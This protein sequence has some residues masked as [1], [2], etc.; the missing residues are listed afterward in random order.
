M[1][2]R[3]EPLTRRE[4]KELQ[5][6]VSWTTS[7]LRV[8]LFLAVVAVVAALSM[9]LQRG[10]RLPDWLWPIP[11]VAATIALFLLAR[12]WTGGT[13]FR[14]DVRLDLEENS[15]LV[16]GVQIVDAIVFEEREDE[17]PVVFVLTAS[18]ETLVFTGQDLA[19]AVARGFPWRE[20]EIRETAH[21]HRLLRLKKIGQ[22]LTVS[23]IRPPLSAGAY[24]RLGLADVGRWQ[25][26]DVPFN[27]LRQVDTQSFAIGD[28]PTI[29]EQKP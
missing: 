29:L 6:Y 19:R 8:L 21:S 1:M 11:T 9:R 27:E 22:P 7:F 12:R 25:R 23:K 26:L 15:A 24:H 3:Q 16:Y 4:R 10:L 2:P 14:H 20:F 28:E 5:G 13:R 18:G 17:G